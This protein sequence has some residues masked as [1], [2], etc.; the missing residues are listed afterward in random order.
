MSE[1][2]CAYLNREFEV[3]HVTEK[4]GIY[5]IVKNS[6]MKHFDPQCTGYFVKTKFAKD[7][8]KQSIKLCEL[9]N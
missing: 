9:F 8:I 2:F 3:G 6:C 1:M 5:Y 7:I 4:N